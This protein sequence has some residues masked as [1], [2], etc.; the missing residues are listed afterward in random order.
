MPVCSY[1]CIY[2]LGKLNFDFSTGDPRFMR[3]SLVRISLLPI[4]KTVQSY[5]AYAE[6]IFVKKVGAIVVCCSI[7]FRF[8]LSFD[9]GFF[10]QVG[11][12]KTVPKKN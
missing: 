3:I 4:L 9:S 10:T 1:N 6:I 11:D 8:Q 2:Y 12:L 5:L 7:Y